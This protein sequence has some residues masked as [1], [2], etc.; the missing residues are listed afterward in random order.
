MRSIVT[1]SCCGWYDVGA[2]SVTGGVSANSRLREV[3]EK[4]CQ[5]KG[6]KVFFPHLSLC[7]DNAAMIAAAGYARLQRG[8]SSDLRLN[9]FPNA[10]LGV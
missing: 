5:E 1:S 9:V 10:P 6:F 3:F 4:T 7:T 8:E 2:V